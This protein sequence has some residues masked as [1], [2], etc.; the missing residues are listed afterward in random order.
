[1]PYSRISIALCTYNGAR[2]LPDLLHSLSKQTL[3]PDE[4]IICDD[5]SSDST[6][7]CIENS[8]PYQSLPGKVIENKTR[9]GVLNNYSKAISMCTGDYIAL[10][11]QDDI[12]IP[13]KLELKM[14]RMK[15]A[16]SAFGTKMPLLVHSDLSVIDLSGK[17]ISKSFFRNRKLKHNFEDP[18][19]VL[20]AQNFVT[21]CTILINRP[22]AELALPIPENAVQHDWWLALFAAAK[23]KI[24]FEPSPTVFYRLHDKNVIG[25][26]GFYTWENITRVVKLKDLEQKLGNIVKQNDIFK[27]RLTYFSDQSQLVELLEDYLRALHRGGVAAV[28]KS[29]K[30]GV[31]MI[32]L[33]RHTLFIMLLLKGDYTKYL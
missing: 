10:C 2:F 13:N 9:I 20:L 18:L 25:P 22:L 21:G 19:K 27:E 14:Q 11:D 8:L 30:Y 15:D 6:V 32:G 3:A 29:L 26:K 4:L 5:A 7:S 31:K 24:I 23:G 12:W 16:E 33:I 28:I 17:V 1:M